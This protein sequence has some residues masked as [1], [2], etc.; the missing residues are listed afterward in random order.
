MRQD[1]VY[2]LVMIF[3]E[4]LKYDEIRCLNREEELGDNF[5]GAAQVDELDIGKVQ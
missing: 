1:V 2:G 4:T 3:P 5:V